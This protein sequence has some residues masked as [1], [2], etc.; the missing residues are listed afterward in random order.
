MIRFFPLVLALQAFCIYHAYNN[1]GGQSWWYFVIIFLPLAGSLA[2]LYVHFYSRQKVDMIQE[3]VKVALVENYKLNKL[4][5]QLKFSDTH[6]N[7]MEL[8]AEHYKVGNYDRATEIYE[9]SKQGMFANDPELNLKLLET[10]YAADNHQKVIELGKSLAEVKE[11][12]QSPEKI[13]YAWSFHKLGDDASADSVFKEMDN[14]YANYQGRIEYV[15]F[16]LKKES[17]QALA[18]LTTLMEEINLMDSYEKRLYKDSI[19]QIK[20]LYKENT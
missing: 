16:L 3:E 4:E 20:N 11:F 5:D 6:T 7:R 13:A 14:D 18:K 9:S 15:K 10:Y 12:S 1:K 17:D 2:Y 19:K 8:A